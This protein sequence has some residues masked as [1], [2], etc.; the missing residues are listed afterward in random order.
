MATNQTTSVT[1][2]GGFLNLLTLAFIVLKLTHYIDWSWW[3]VL[4]PLWI[5]IALVIVLLVLLGMVSA[6]VRPQK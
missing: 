4:A 3:W 2:G 1:V 5:P 6:F